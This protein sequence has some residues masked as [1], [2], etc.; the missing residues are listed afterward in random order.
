MQGDGN[1]CARQRRFHCTTRVGDECTEHACVDML[2]VEFEIA[3]EVI[4]WVGVGKRH[5]YRVERG[6]PI[7]GGDFVRGQHV[8][9]D[10]TEIQAGA[11]AS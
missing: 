7:V 5:D 3:D 4:D 1:D 9:A 2:A 6:E 10:L 8:Q 11:L